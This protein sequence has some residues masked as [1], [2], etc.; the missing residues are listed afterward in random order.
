MEHPSA[1]F[2]SLSDS[3]FFPTSHAK[4]AATLTKLATGH[5]GRQIATSKGKGTKEGQCIKGR[6]LL[7][8]V[9][10]HFR[11]GEVESTLF[12]LQDLISAQLKN[13]DVRTFMTSWEAMLV[14][15]TKVP[16]DEVLEVLF[17]QQLRK[18]AVLEQDLAFYDRLDADNKN[19]Q[20]LLSSLRRHLER[21]RIEK[22]S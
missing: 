7:L 3:G 18:S 6:Q 13:G 16:H 14:G 10:K 4:L 21:K 17:L 22:R 12:N 8:L 1:T 19:Y 5:L 20:F 11:L 2:D 15:M 9:Y